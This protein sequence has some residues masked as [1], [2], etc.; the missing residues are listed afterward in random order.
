MC[1]SWVGSALVM[2]RWWSSSITELKN[3]I[4]SGKNVTASCLLYPMAAT[5][6]SVFASPAARAMPK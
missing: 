5:Y 4:P 2:V 1:R 6:M 3:L